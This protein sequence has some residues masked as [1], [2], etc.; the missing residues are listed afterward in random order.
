MYNLLV[1]ADDKAW[2]GEPYLIEAARCVREYTDTDITKRY[3]ELD[4]TAISELQRLPCIFAYEA[5]CK[6][7][8][9]FGVIRNITKRQGRVRIEYQIKEI[10]PFLTIDDLTILAFELDI[11]KLEMNR[12]HWAVKNVNLAKELKP[13]GIVLPGWTRSVS[14]A[15]DI[16]VHDFEVALSFP[17]EARALI[18]PIVV[19][20]EREIGPNAYFYDSNYVS[21]L[22]RP[23]LDMLLQDIYGHRSKLVVVFLSGDY[24][25]KEWCSIEFRAVQEII[26]KRDRKKIMFVKM[27]DGPVDGVFKTDGFVDGR[28]FSPED[29]ARFIQE[30]IELLK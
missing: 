30:R 28:K 8:P 19:A 26:M 21:Q 17:G 10:E 6:K 23:S 4:A 5:Y 25:R 13:R 12:T 20:L 15:V 29:I 14:K 24:Q 16:T 3:A 2:E 1:S 27:D 7:A 11:G 22:A 9:K 18:E